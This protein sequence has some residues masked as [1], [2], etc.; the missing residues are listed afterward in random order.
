MR[1]KPNWAGHQP[2]LWEFDDFLPESLPRRSEL[3]PA[4]NLISLLEECHNHIYAN[5]GMLKEKVFREIVKLL[6]IKL[7][8]ECYTQ[9][10]VMEFGI[11]A[12]EYR[13]IL[14]GEPS[15]FVARLQ[16]LYEQMRSDFSQFFP[17]PRIYLSPLS[18]AYVVHKLQLVYLSQTPADVKGEA[19]Q[20]FFTRYQRGDRGEFF[21]PQPIVELAVEMI[22]PKPWETVVDPACGSGGFLIQ[23]VR[24]M[25]E[26][27]R[28]VNIPEY[29]SE[30]LRGIE[31]NP[32]IAT[33]AQ[34]RLALE[35]AQGI[36]ILCANA[37]EVGLIN[38]GRYDIVLANPPFGS[39]GKISDPQILQRYALGYRWQRNT[40]GWRPTQSLLSGQTPE[41]LFI[42]LCVRLLRPGGRL[43]IVLPDGVLQNA[44]TEHVRAWLRTSAELAAVVSL[45][46]HAFVPYGTGIKT[47]LLILVKHPVSIKYVFMA[48]PQKI[49]YDVKGQPLYQCDERG[50]ITY[51]D[52]GNPILDT[53]LPELANLFCAG[54]QDTAPNPKTFWTPVDMLN[55]RLDA[56][57]YLPE[58]ALMLRQLHTYPSRHLHEIADIVTEAEP[59]HTAPEQLIR[60][61]AISDVIPQLSIIASTQTLRA[62]EA[63]SRAKYRLKKGD[64]ITA[65]SGASTG[66][67]Q[68]ASAIVTE[69]EDG[70]ICT[71]GFAV[72]RNFREVNP[73]YLLAFLRSEFFLRQVRRLL[74]G[75]AIPAITLEDLGEVIVPLPPEP[76]QSAIGQLI[77]ESIV[78]YRKGIQCAQNAASML[79]DILGIVDGATTPAT[80]E[81]QLP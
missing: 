56:E 40:H 36:Q 58:D 80:F 10:L 43:A 45:P 33:A 74:R 25:R 24:Y 50:Q 72:L 30:K 64:I 55:H 61:V 17:D 1:T 48:I 16:R 29:I 54:P 63:P 7:Y 22:A 65:I 11:T 79:Q 39:R 15:E 41:I 81:V 42:E 35:G 31:F 78:A 6:A 53:D 71:N 14:N 47:S 20:V 18:L 34:V 66:T 23:T 52:Q 70:A 19:F 73:Y 77:R 44:T 2:E 21:T 27:F 13:A 68:H 60:Y 5:E 57:H 67:I 51:G 3:R 49:G 12:S 32:D 4:S 75:H 37:L 26:N 38:E 8:E 69:M 46:Q 76:Q 28:D 9:R 62:C 59:L